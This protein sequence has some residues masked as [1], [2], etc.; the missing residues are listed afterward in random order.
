MLFF[1]EMMTVLC[2]NLNAR[3]VK[4]WFFLLFQTKQVAG[5]QY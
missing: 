3:D 2:F 5:H 4:I 1:M